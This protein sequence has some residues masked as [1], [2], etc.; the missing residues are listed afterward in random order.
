MG[1]ECPSTTKSNCFDELIYGVFKNIAT[2]IDAILSLPGLIWGGI[3]SLFKSEGPSRDQLHQIE[4]SEDK[5]VSGMVADKA[6]AVIDSVSGFF[7]AMGTMID[8]SIKDNFGCEEWSSSRVTLGFGEEPKCLK[9]VVSWKCATCSQALN[10]SCGILGFA[11]GEIVTAYLTGGALSMVKTMGTAAK[12]TKV[13]QAVGAVASKAKATKMYN[14]LATGAKY[15]S[16]PLVYTGKKA[17]G[18]IKFSGK[19]A[20]GIVKVGRKWMIKVGKVLMPV[21]KATKL[22]ILKGFLKAEKK[23]IGAATFVPKKYFQA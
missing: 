10:M 16:K 19:A 18:V 8:E 14:A 7:N 4:H 23:V 15:G 6:Q 21:S 17:I 5:K 1:I 11:G 13:G 2:N 3:K 22:K 20:T 12:A 9:P